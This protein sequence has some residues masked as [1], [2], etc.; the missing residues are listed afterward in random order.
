MVQEAIHSNINKNHK[1]MIIK[2]D[3]A[4]DFDRVRQS[5]FD[6]LFK[7]CFSP[8]FI[9]LVSSCI[10][11]PWFSLLVNGGFASFF[12]ESHGLR[13]GYPLTPLLYIIMVESLSQKLEE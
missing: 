6:I 13:H 5:L 1:G 7:F 3:M 10:S 2:I 12:Q 9:N 4:N 8:S 11:A